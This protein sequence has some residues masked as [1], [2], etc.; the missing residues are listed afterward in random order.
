VVTEALRARPRRSPVNVSALATWVIGV[1][2][3]VALAAIAVLA[4]PTWAIAGA[5]AA[6]I[7]VF[8][9]VLLAPEAVVPAAWVLVVFVGVARKILAGPSGHTTNDPLIAAP[10]ALLVPLLFA[11]MWWG[12]RYRG[13]IWLAVA[14]AVLVF[15]SFVVALLQGNTSFVTIRAAV[16][17]IVAPLCAVVLVHPSMRGSIRATLVAVRISALLAAIYGIYQY[18][19]PPRWDLRFIANVV[20]DQG[21]QS[22]GQAA[23]GQFRLFG[24]TQAPLAFSIVLSLG[25]VCWAFWE[26]RLSVRLLAIAVMTVPLLL[27]SVRTS[28]FALALT[29]PVVALVHYR[30]RAVVPLVVILAAVAAIPTILSVI[31][32]DLI[33]RFSVATLGSD[34][35]FNSRVRLL[36][37][38]SSSILGFGGGPGASNRGS[39]VT[40]NG[41]LAAFID[42]GTLGGVLLILLLLAALYAAVQY[43]LRSGSAT[44]GL[45]L[46]IVLVYV[47]AEASAPVVQSQQGLIF[48]VVLALLGVDVVRHRGVRNIGDAERAVLPWPPAAPEPAPAVLAR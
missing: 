40:D 1:L 2:A 5:I 23:R 14:F 46:A 11:R 38:A 20:V 16:E 28:V 25:I 19:A 30:R 3:V 37:T 36:D 39:R 17:Q 22:F 43:A 13:H 31:A 6:T 34:T 33:N 47:L 44:R 26:G 24:P 8:A 29:L 21:V 48:W 35:S 7:V 32:P 15:V 45:P 42:F 18:V 9:L 41:Y 27:T 4:G 10:Y 12:S